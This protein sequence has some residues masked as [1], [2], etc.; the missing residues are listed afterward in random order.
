MNALVGHTGFVGSNLAETGDFQYFFNSKNI[1]DA[2]GLTPDL[3]IY[4][5]IPAE[6]FLANKEP[7]ADFEII[8]NAI[9][10]IS[11]IQPKSIVLISTVD[12]Y[13]NPNGVSESTEINI[14]TVQPYGKNRLFLER[15]VAENFDDYLIVRLPGLF[16]SNL[17]KNF[18]FDLI[19][20]IPSMLNSNKMEELSEFDWV[21]SNYT[22]QPN[23]FYKINE[24]TINDRKQLKTKFLELGFSALNFTDSRA[25]FQF[26]PLDRLWKDIQVA[27]LKGIRTL[28][29]ATA[30]IA[31][32]EIYEAIYGKTFE[33]E[34]N[35]PVPYYD[36][37]SEY[38]E[39]FGKEGHYIASKSE[40]LQSILDFINA[41]K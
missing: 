5:G 4:S 24:L 12:V 18:I 6:K 25:V 9:Q 11:K 37:H 7:E 15:W 19:S 13:P 21:T 32:S 35:N 22:L 28:N 1:S 26:Y 40:I 31:V 29:L 3:L 10:N 27:R 33:N 39:Y 2:F 17:K 36:F 41:S 34:L 14:N 38:A 30:P 8:Q 16:G 23:G 20:V